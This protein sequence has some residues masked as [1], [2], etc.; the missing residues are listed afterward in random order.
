MRRFVWAALI[1]VT[2]GVATWAGA[3]LGQPPTPES[4]QSRQ[5]LALNQQARQA[6]AAGDY[7]KVVGLLA[8]TAEGCVEAA[9]SHLLRGIA[10]WKLNYWERAERSW[11]E[12][13]RVDP[14]VPEAGWRLLYIYFVMQRTREAEQLV[15]ELHPIEPDRQDR[16]RLLLELVRQEFERLGPAAAAITIE[17]VVAAEP[18]N[19]HALRVLGVSYVMLHRTREGLELIRRAI[20]QRP[21][22]L[23]A[24][25]NLVWAYTERGDMD[26]LTSV[27][28]RLPAE[29]NDDPRFLR[30][31]SVWAE[32]MGERAEA[33]RLLQRALAKDPWDRK[34][35]Y[36]LARLLRDRTAAEADAHESKARD[37]DESRE[38]LADC[39]VRA[40]QQGDDPSPQLCQDFAEACRALGRTHLAE[41][42]QREYAERAGASARAGLSETGSAR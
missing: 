10:Y 1:I 32:A 23:E 34:A 28:P 13:L 25:F 36:Q 3:R 16:V 39:Y 7:A 2:F 6:L 4:Q 12:A 20:D 42:W 26:Q 24:W 5:T 31:R 33:E 29:S 14:K 17:P 8:D 9:E 22:V 37:I 40:A 41:S 18:E 30:L 21:D 35:H 11:R 38:R 27:W 15:L 19:Y